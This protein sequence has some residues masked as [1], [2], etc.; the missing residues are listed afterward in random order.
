MDKQAKIFV[1]GHRGMVGSALV[2]RLQ[3]GGYANVLTASR[4]E[5]DL[6]D[7][8]AVHEYLAR[9]K[10]DYLFIAAAKVGGIQANN[11]QRADFIYQNLVIEANLIHGAHLAGVQRLMFLGSSCIYPRDCPQP[12]REEYLLTGPLEPTNEPYAIA[13]IAGI[14]LCE[15]YNRQHGRQYVSVMP[16]NL[17]GPNDN[18]D[19]ANSH[20]L[21]A[22]LRKAHEA[23]LRGDTE[24]VVWGSGTPRREFLYVDDLADACV[25]LME[26]GWD[27]ELVN[28]GT[29]QDVTIREL[30]ETVMRV[31]GFEGRIVF[32]A[33]KPDGTPRKLLDVSRLAALG[34]RA[35][36]PLE[37]GIRLAYEAAPFKH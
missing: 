22:L 11:L 12:I 32:D 3:A 5:L 23:K 36:T 17:Y 33:T 30:A 15:S 25:H 20:V 26:R 21:P 14:K 8:R 10:P 24:Y 4:A 35:R 34:W 19:L 28:I 27:G 18:Y 6:L 31:V 13:K 1:A 29:G 7:Q 9:E 2:R 16:T 37:D